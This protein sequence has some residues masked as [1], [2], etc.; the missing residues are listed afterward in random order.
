MVL[1][2]RENINSS[3]LLCPC[4]EHTIILNFFVYCLKFWRIDNKQLICR[5]YMLISTLVCL[6]MLKTW[7]STCHIII[8]NYYMI[9]QCIITSAPSQT[10]HL[11]ISSCISYH[12]YLV[13]ENLMLSSPNVDRS[14]STWFPSKI[15]DALFQLKYC[16][17]NCI[18]YHKLLTSDFKMF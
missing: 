9:F 18:I 3:K 14:I 4:A 7:I 11:S 16:F 1:F 6:H 10:V 17:N 5:W 12:D 15:F 2:I 13:N 8:N